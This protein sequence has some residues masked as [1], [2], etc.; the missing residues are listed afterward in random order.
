V[1]ASRP[2]RFAAAA[3]LF[4]AA[5]CTH[6][7]STDDGTAKKPEKAPA[8]EAPAKPRAE[9]PAHEPAA[10]HER[11]ADETPLSTAPAG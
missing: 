6:T 1:T 4:V 8:E 3:L 7:K 11:A 10:R 9:T 5:G 2:V